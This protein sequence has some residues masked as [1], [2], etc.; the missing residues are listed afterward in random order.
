[1]NDDHKAIH[2]RRAS[3]TG[4]PAPA[5]R[6]APPAVFAQPTPDQAQR[7]AGIM[8]RLSLSTGFAKV[9]LRSRVTCSAR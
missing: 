6:F 3:T 7:G 1:M 8:R 5:G 9:S 4:W 2:P